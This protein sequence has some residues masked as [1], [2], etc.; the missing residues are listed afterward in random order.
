MRPEARLQ[1]AP[2][3]QRRRIGIGDCSISPRAKALVLE[4]L[5]G[6]RLSAGPL[7]QR[8]EH[9]FAELHGCAFG[10]MSNSGTSALQIALGAM[11]ERGGWQDGDEVLVPALTF[12]ASSNVVLYNALT[13]VFVDVEPDF[14]CMDPAQIERRLTDRTRAIMPVHVAGLPCDMDPILEV[15]QA[16]GLRILEDSAE[17]VAVRYKGRPVGSLGDVGCF[18]TYIAHLV[19][20]GVGGLCTTNDAGL[21]DIM[22]SLMNHGRDAVYTRIDDDEDLERVRALDLASRR[23]SFVRL[24]HSF[25]ATEMEAALGIAQLEERE[26]RDARRLA[27]VSRL[28]E[29]LRSLDAYLQLPRPRPG[30]DHAYMFFPLLVRDP[31]SRDDLVD[32]LEQNGVET[33]HLLPLIRQPIY[34]RLFGDL[35]DEYPVAARLDETAFYIGC[36]PELEDAD[37]D[38]VIDVFHAYFAARR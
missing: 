35:D 26:W 38:Y 15:A 9:D 7:M 20:T 1:R 27:V 21:H 12:V 19:T 16:H 13:P 3:T 28:T 6:N 34:R 30:V 23:F 2:G 37:V 18:S 17:A 31:I 36:Q 29:A 14:F 25:R 32:H 11:K 33:R 22:K 5:D 8:F 10:L 4:A 24:G